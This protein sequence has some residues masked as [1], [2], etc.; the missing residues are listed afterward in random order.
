[1][2]LENEIFTGRNIIYFVEDLKGGDC[3]VGCSECGTE[4]PSE[5]HRI[6]KLLFLYKCPKCKKILSYPQEVDW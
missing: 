4:F 3:V 1:M 6:S 2:I 5:K